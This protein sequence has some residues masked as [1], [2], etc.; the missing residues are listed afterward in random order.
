MTDVD[1]GTP[2]AANDDYFGK[3]TTHI[4][5][6]DDAGNWVGITATV[7]TFMGSKVSH[8]RHRDHHE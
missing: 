7:N 6:A 5:A 2:P 1:H 4:A 8:P 3:H